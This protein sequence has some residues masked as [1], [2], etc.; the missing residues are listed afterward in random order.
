MDP[1]CET[2]INEKIRCRR[3][4]IDFLYLNL[5]DK[6]LQCNNKSCNF[7][8]KADNIIWNCQICDKSFHS[9][10]KIYNPLEAL[11][12][13]DVIK[14]TLLLKKKAHPN[15]VFC[16]KDFVNL[17]TTNF[18]HKKEC[19]GLLYFGEYDSKDII[20]CE[21]CKAINLLNKFIWTCPHCENR[22]NE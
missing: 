6:K 20:V 15:K 2:L 16:C 18:Y 21:K 5:K 19:K 8:T 17:N 4:N 3:C 9:T 12:I 22:F 13:M 1:H 7:S 10:L 14:M 11:E